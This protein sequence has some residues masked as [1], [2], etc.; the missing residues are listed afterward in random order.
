MPS[1][2]PLPGPAVPTV[3]IERVLRPIREFIRLEASAGL[4]LLLAA[5][6]A[7]VWANSP[8]RGAYD[9]LWHVPVT[10]G[11]DRFVLTMDLHHW[12]NDGLM[13]LFF[14]LVGLEI[15]R[16]ALMGELASLRRAALPIAAALGGMVVPALIYA[17]LNA[18]GPGAAGWGIPMATDIAFALGVLA[19]L[20]KRVP[21]A[22]KVF[23]TALAVVDDLGAVL[24]IALFYT[25][26]VSWSA[27]AAAAALL[28]A[29]AAAGRLGVRRPLVYALIGLPL[30]LAVLLSGVHAT[31]AGVLL[32]M[33]IPTRSRIDAHA[34]AVRGQ[35]YLDEFRSASAHDLRFPS[36]APTNLHQQASLHE[37]EEA[38]E[39]V[40]TPL[41]RMEHALHPWVAYAIMPV[42]A[43]A[44]AGVALG[45]DMAELV[46]HPVALGVSAGLVF[47]KQ[48]GITLFAWLATRLGL[49]ALPTGVTWR[50]VYG[51]AWLGGIGFT[52]SLFISGLAFAGDDALLTASKVGILEASLICGGV[53]WLILRGV[54]P[55][56]APE[57][58]EWPDRAAQPA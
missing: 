5:A 44:N 8:W 15:K 51:A 48:I 45:G 23:L 18:G 32:A 21:L 38:A 57:E 56:V 34:F 39:Q 28:A 50:H 9:A 20:G 17:A 41:H 6:I 7:I 52:M 3:P 22:L 11:A 10:M 43:F 33:V 27:L 55:P 46:Q 13:V 29:A 16:E 35:A 40:Q 54:R 2:S 24:V 4:L 58:G 1:P 36:V 25:P 12:I 49:A 31:V 42:F 14:F 47:G 26:S 53:G 37:L 30:W 19:L